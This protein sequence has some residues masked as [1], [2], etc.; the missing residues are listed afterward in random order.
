[1][2]PLSLDDLAAVT[3]ARRIGGVGEAEVDHVVFDSRDA[4]PGSLFVALRG[5]RVDGH[6]F[7]VDAA[8]RGALAVLGERVVEGLP[9]LVVP[10]AARALA[11]LGADCR[12]RSPARFV[13]ITG[14]NGKTT[15]KELLA[16]ILSGA[17]STLATA[18]NRNNL[19]GVPETL[20]RLEARHRYAVIEMGA[21]H[22]GEIAELTRWVRPHVGVVTNAGPAHLE[23]FGSIDGVAHA[24][25]E[26]FAGLPADG[27]AVIHADDPYAG[28]WRE[29]AGARRCLTF[30]REAGQIR[31]RGA[32]A[33]LAID[34]GDGF[35]PMPTV[36]AGEHNAANVAAAA[37]CAAALG[38]GGAA[39][40]DGVAAARPAPGRLEL[41]AG[42]HGGWVL[43]D[44]YNANPASVEA[45]L[46]VLRELEGRP[47]LILGGMAELGDDADDWHAHVGRLAA[48]H[49]LEGVW[50]L[51]AAAPAA[52]A[53]GAGGRVFT[54][55]QALLRACEQELPA[56]AAV[57]IKGSRSAGMEA[58]VAGLAA[59]SNNIG[60]GV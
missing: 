21:N 22:A 58:V 19:L 53:F 57:L 59:A 45:A 56:G 26:L 1:M 32:G 51:H 18:G 35:Q 34:L 17:G 33:D 30:G 55:H 46:Q 6:E 3:G 37:A 43:D 2:D 50:A 40:R 31:Y 39:I 38:V 52:A 54:D 15:V 49:G 23:G 44:S 11:A 25:G 9:T 48:Q 28:L 13:A 41:R 24:K 20:C 47:W 8:R 36:L 12:S 7:A 60:E 14:S 4:R 42:R 10:D 16:S 29:L 27:V 5:S